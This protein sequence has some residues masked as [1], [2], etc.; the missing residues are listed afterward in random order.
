MAGKSGIGKSLLVQGTHR[1]LSERRSYVAVRKLDRFKRSPPLHGLIE[2]FRALLRAHA[3][4]E[5]EAA[6]HDLLERLRDAFRQQRQADRRCHPR[7]ECL[8]RCA[9]ERDRGRRHRSQEPL[10]HDASALHASAATSAQPLVLFLDQL[11]WADTSTAALLEQLATEEHTAQQALF[12]IGAF[13]SHEN[14]RSARRRKSQDWCSSRVC[15]S[16][17]ASTISQG[18]A[19]AWPRRAELQTAGCDIDT[20]TMRVRAAASCISDTSAATRAASSRSQ[21]AAEQH[22]AHEHPRSASRRA[23]P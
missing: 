11:P 1:Q 2:A 8:A 9:A 22:A 23:H 3:D 17:Q 19:S 6:V 5:D 12:F 7:A 4:G 20:T 21:P 13:S 14:R 10:S 18:A 15:P 16:R